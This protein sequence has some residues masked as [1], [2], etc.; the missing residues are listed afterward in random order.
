MAPRDQGRPT[1]T[2]S[3]RRGTASWALKE[4]GTLKFAMLYQYDIPADADVACRPRHHQRIALAA[5]FGR[6]AADVSRAFGAGGSLRP[7]ADRAGAGG[8]AG[9]GADTGQQGIDHCSGDGSGA[10]E[11]WRGP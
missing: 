5:R 1:V 11:T 9:V 10:D 3:P 6:A 7:A 4:S 8:P 2:G